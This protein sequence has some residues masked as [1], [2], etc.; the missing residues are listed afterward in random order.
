MV[1]FRDCRRELDNAA[2]AVG[3]CQ[4]A[5][6]ALGENALDLVADAVH[7]KFQSRIMHA[8]YGA[9]GVVGHDRDRAL[10]ALE[11]IRAYLGVE[12]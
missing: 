1:N 12:K 9:A 11:V 5:L 10:K 7:L 3:R 4:T 2:R 6:N 8:P